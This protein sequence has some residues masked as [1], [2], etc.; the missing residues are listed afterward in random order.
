M[1]LPNVSVRAGATS[2][3]VGKHAHAASAQRPVY[4]FRCRG[5]LRTRGTRTKPWGL[6]TTL[7]TRK[8]ALPLLE[9]SRLNGSMTFTNDFINARIAD[10]MLES[11]RRPKPD[12]IRNEA[13]GQRFLD[14]TQSLFTQEQ[15]QPEAGS[16]ESFM[17][18]SQGPV[19]YRVIMLGLIR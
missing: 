9:E 14:A 11:N 15:L 12:Y 7:L 19:L 3:K 8:A 16:M 18:I 5:T 1:C 17:L 4:D 10:V 13:D 2:R 6:F